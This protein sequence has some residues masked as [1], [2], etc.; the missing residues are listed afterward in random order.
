VVCATDA[1]LRAGRDDQ[2]VGGQGKALASGGGRLESIQVLRAVAAIGVVFT[3]AITRLSISFPGAGDHAVFTGLGGQLT[4]GDA[5][6]DLFF[7]ISGFIMLHVHRNDFARPGAPLRFMSRRILRIVPI[8]WLLTTLALVFLIFAPQLFTTHYQRIY[9]PWIVGSYLFLPIAPPGWNATPVVGV[10]WT[11][12]YEMF[13]YAVFAGALHL[14][15][16]LGLQ[17]IFVCFGVLVALGVLWR[18]SVPVL[19]LV[20]NWLLFDFLM[21]I[22]IAWWLLSSGKL[23]RLP[24]C[25]LISI[26]IAC[27]AAT[28]VWPPP[29]EG[30]LRFLLWGI[31]AALVVFGMSSVS[32]PE[33]GF[34]RLMSVLG[35]AS[36]SIYLFQFF[37]LPGWARVMCAA[38]AEAIPFDAN[39]LILTALVTASGYGCWLLLERPLGT[40]ARSWSHR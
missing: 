9:L 20:T 16:R 36:Y 40:V 3:H 7:V 22:A 26:G 29:E 38:G 30:P 28:I 31:P 14:P 37:A 6:V 1:S 19:S 17:L 34:G 18:P 5:G 15:R 10:G 21:G 24:I 33:G 2:E 39:V 8:Y 12:N 27:L 4:V 35:D 13:F 32:I 23:S 25:V 11:L